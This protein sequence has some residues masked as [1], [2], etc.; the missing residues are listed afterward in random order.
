[1]TRPAQT[2]SPTRDAW[3]RFRKH[4]LAVVSLVVLGLLSGSAAAMRSSFMFAKGRGDP[5]AT[6]GDVKA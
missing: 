3:R 4:R 6:Q 1:M 2:Y 5:L